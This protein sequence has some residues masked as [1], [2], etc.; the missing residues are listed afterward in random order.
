[1]TTTDLS[2][3]TNFTRVAV[4]TANKI[5]AYS[6]TDQSVS[7]TRDVTPSTDWHVSLDSED[8]FRLGCRNVSHQQ[9]SFSR[10]TM[11]WTITLDEL[12]IHLDANHLL[13]YFNTD[14][15]MQLCCWS[16]AG[17]VLGP[18]DFTFL[19]ILQL[20]CVLHMVPFWESRSKLRVMQIVET[21]GMHFKMSWE[22]I[23]IIIIIIITIPL[24]NEGNFIVINTL[25]TFGPPT[26]VVGDQISYLWITDDKAYNMIFGKL[27]SGI[28][29]WKLDIDKYNNTRFIFFVCRRWWQSP[30]AAWD[31]YTSP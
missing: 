29:E 13:C 1:M 10:P 9:K 18:Y 30:S 26:S 15:T 21:D 7:R 31:S 16:F 3:F 24:F 22:L 23:I 5:T 25:K 17:L 6:V 12:L 4:K 2:L 20:S 11:T 28:T 27:I 14:L 8:D 19:L